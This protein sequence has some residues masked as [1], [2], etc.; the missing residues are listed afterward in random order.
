MVRPHGQDFDASKKIKGH[1]RHLV[2]DTLGLL[3]AVNVTAVNV[4]D[5]DGAASV[6][7]QACAKET[8]LK[9]LYADSAYGGQCVLDLEK[10][11]GIAV[12]IVRRLSNR[13]TGKF[14]AEQQLWPQASSYRPSA[15]WPSART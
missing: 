6:V 15:G 11:H 10:K 14:L 3:P 2:V 5:R 7:A 1:K 13:V 12:E 9:R 4:Q 8:G